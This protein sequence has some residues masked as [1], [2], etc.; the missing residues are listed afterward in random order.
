MPISYIPYNLYNGYIH[1]WLVAGPQAILIEADGDYPTDQDTRQ[2]IVRDHYEADSGI[3]TMPV[4][5]GPLTE[6]TFTVG[7]Y[8]G[9]WSYFRCRDDH[10]VDFTMAYSRCYYVRS[11]AYAHI[12]SPI[13]QD[14]TLCITTHG[15]ADVWVNGVHVHNHEYFSDRCPRSTRF[16]VTLQEGHNEVLVRFET[17]TTQEWSHVMAL[18]V[19]EPAELTAMHVYLPTTIAQLD[20]RTLLERIVQAAY[21]QQDVF[22]QSDEIVVRWPESPGLQTDAMVRLQTPAGRI[23]GE[24]ITE[25]PSGD[26]LSLDYTY[27]VPDGPYRVVLMPGPTEYYHNNVRVKREL[28]VWCIGSTTYSERAYGT[29]QERRQKALVHAAQRQGN[30]FSEIAK[31]A[32]GAWPQVKKDVIAQTIE[33]INHRWDNSER[34]L[35]GLLGML[36]RFGDHPAF[37]DSFRTPLAECI[38]GFAYQTDEPTR[39]ETGESLSVLAYTCA[40]LAGQL[41]S[42]RL[43]VKIGKTGRW[44]REQGETLVLTWLRERGAGGFTAWDSNDQ[45]EMDLTALSY[46]ADLAET[47]AVWEMASVIMDKLFFTLALNSY[48]GV[49]GSTHGRTRA[50]FVKGGLLE[51]TA[52]I[53]RLMWGMGIYNHH[54]GGTVSLACAEDYEFP[55]IIGDIATALPDEMWNHERHVLASYHSEGEVNKVT[56]KTPDYMLCSAQDYHPGK[57]GDGEHIWQ[58]TMGPTAVVFVTHPR[59]AREDD[60]HRSNFWC[61]NRVLPRVAQWKDVLIAIHNMPENDWMGFT[62]AYFPIYAFDDYVLREDASGHSWAFAKKEEGYLALVASQGFTLITEG[63]SAYR[64]LRSY[65][66]HNIWLCYMGRV[67]LD[68]DFSAFQEKVLALDI[69]FA[70]L[71]LRCATLRGETLTFGWEEPLVRNGQAQ[72]I[73][74][75]RHYETPYCIT[76]LSA[77]QMQIQ[78]GE[79]ALRLK[80]EI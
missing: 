3:V 75:F 63:Y 41:Y 13:P 14:V 49:F 12:I 72:P 27:R 46:L 23:Y 28:P 34:D 16:K 20:R 33:R 19:C 55:P 65:G 44:L 9:A 50:S 15:S 37:P 10:F 26:H 61:G 56:Y 30:I 8:E 48:K 76:E 32:L 6:G 43:F 67:R 77:P 35:A 52:G 11:W 71:S 58:A 51:A 29:Y 7:A 47:E 53:S 74:E 21:L 38:L 79:Y 40:I 73:K 64:E 60:A 69:H 1:N 68:G 62:H 5:R 36:Y 18:Q 80:Y 31:M 2:K 59:N 42:D 54:I 24:G 17:V 39:C 45:F 78:F 25:R 70:E 4:E 57:E 66:H 22:A